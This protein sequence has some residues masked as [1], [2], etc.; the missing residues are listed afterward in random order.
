MIVLAV[1]MGVCYLGGFVLFFFRMRSAARRLDARS[2]TAMTT[3]LSL[4]FI[5]PFGLGISG[6]AM[7][8]G[9]QNAALTVAVLSSVSIFVGL[10]LIPGSLMSGIERLEAREK[11]ACNERFNKLMRERV[12]ERKK[13]SM[14]PVAAGSSTEIRS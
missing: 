12:E 13:R 4:A 10:W 3:G 2:E 1:L 7:I 8:F 11:D 5:I 6:G 9:S 14:V